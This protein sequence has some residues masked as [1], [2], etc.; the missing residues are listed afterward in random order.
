MIERGILGGTCV[1]VGCIPSKNLLGIG[2]Q[3]ISAQKPNS[4][5]ITSCNSNFD[6]TKAIL[7]KDNLVKGLRQKKYS[8]VLSSFSN[9]D[10]IEGE[11]S[12]ISNRKIRVSR[13]KFQDYNN[14]NESV[15]LESDKFIIA[16]GSSPYIPSF[17]GIE[18]IDY[19]TNIEALSLKEKPSSM[20]VIGG[21]ALGLEFAQMFA[22]FGTK[23]TLL[24]RSSKIIPEHEPEIADGLHTYL[25][26]E[27]IEITTGV[28]VQ[29][30]YQ[31][32]DSKF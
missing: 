14:S 10:F 4:A 27:G 24:Q 23:V 9:I 5:A 25:T 22:R 12:F 3:I 17:K 20:I 18:N 11:V 6:F 13:V 2:E 31:K 1:N 29:E 32:G 19:L 26:E 7:D 8:D 15:L 30:I 28:N 16:T 21:R